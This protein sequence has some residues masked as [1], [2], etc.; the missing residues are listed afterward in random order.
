VNKCLLDVVIIEDIQV[1]VNPFNNSGNYP[2]I[3]LV[4]KREFGDEKEPG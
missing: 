1:I 4:H 3:L 2:A